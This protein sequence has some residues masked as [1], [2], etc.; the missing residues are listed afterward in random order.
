M[1]DLL[2]IL[3]AKHARLK[4]AKRKTLRLVLAGAVA[5]GLTAPAFAEPPLEKT[6]IRLASRPALKIR[7]AMVH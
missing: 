2:R 7:L 3:R 1:V 4:H 5:L 6:E